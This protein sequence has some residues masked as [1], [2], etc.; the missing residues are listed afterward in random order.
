MSRQHLHSP[1]ARAKERGE[2][3]AAL[4]KL[5]PHSCDPLRDASIVVPFTAVRI[6]RLALNPARLSS[7]SKRRSGFIQLLVLK[8]L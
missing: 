2:R 7:R 8:Q 6:C 3:R 4:Q 5:A 1:R